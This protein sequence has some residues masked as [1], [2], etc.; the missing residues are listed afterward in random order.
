MPRYGVKLRLEG[1]VEVILPNGTKKKIR[2]DRPI[3]YTTGKG[4]NNLVNGND[5]PGYTDNFGNI[6]NSQE[7]KDYINSKLY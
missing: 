2:G 7:L 1:I 3:N 4:A 5:S 6:Y